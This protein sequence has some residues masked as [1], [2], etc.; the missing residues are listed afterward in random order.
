[1]TEMTTSAARVIRLLPD[2]VP[3]QGLEPI[4]LDPADFQSDLP[5]QRW[6]IA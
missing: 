3:G 1:M 2:G 4:D 6:C 5:E